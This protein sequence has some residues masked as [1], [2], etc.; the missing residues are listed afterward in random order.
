MDGSTRWRWA[1]CW[2]VVALVAAL[3][4]PLISTALHAAEP[5]TSPSARQ[6]RPAAPGSEAPL[7]GQRALEGRLLAPCCYQ[8]TLDIHEG[9]VPTQLRAEIRRRLRAGE[10]PE[11]I[12]QD[13]IGRYGERI[14]AVSSDSPMS[15]VSMVLLVLIALAGGGLVFGWRRWGAQDPPDPEPDLEASDRD[16]YD[17]QLDA[18]LRDL[19]D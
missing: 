10:T 15:Y 3:C 1:V 19:D 2:R 17:A 14:V 6:G 4:A 16:R 9:P 11:A 8:Q 18:E 5:N 7:P 13:L 12:E